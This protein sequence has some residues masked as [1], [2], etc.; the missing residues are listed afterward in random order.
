M[1]QYLI[2]PI[3]RAILTA[4]YRSAAYR[5]RF[6]ACHYGTDLYS[7]ASS[8]VFACGKGQVVCAGKDSVVGNTVTVIYEDVWAGDRSRTVAV[9]C[10]HLRDIRVKTGQKVNKDTVL[11]HFGSTGLFVCGAHLHIEIDAD[12]THWQGV[13]GMG[14]ARSTFYYRGGDTMLNPA[15]LLHPYRGDRQTVSYT[16]S[17]YNGRFFAER[18][19]YTPVDT[20]TRE[21]DSEAVRKYEREAAARKK[22]EQA[23]AAAE[24]ENREAREKIRAALKILEG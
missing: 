23:L 11:G 17:K 22:A 13:P 19:G 21:P 6:G 3:N 24:K 14:R 10:F 12:F 18:G 9:R 5:A 7:T 16:D 2:L 20:L 1:S 4:T 15:D 8:T